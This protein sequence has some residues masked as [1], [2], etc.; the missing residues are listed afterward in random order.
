MGAAVR[1]LVVF[2][3]FGAVV[4]GVAA[5]SKP[6]ALIVFGLGT[7]TFGITWSYATIRSRQRKDSSHA[8]RA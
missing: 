3:G 5:W 7:M 2:G 8:R 4:A 6:A 1:T